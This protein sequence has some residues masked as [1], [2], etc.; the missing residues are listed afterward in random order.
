[1][2]CQGLKSVRLDT[3]CC[4]AGESDS[5]PDLEPARLSEALTGSAT[6]RKCASVEVEDDLEGDGNLIGNKRDSA[7]G[8]NE[9]GVTRRIDP[10]VEVLDR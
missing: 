5:D 7:G 9:D 4:E 6:S 8:D 10:P 1:M 2:G 3:G